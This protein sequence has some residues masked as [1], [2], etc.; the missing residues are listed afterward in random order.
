[1]FQ[2]EISKQP[3]AAIGSATAQVAAL[4]FIDNDTAQKRRP[5]RHSAAPPQSRARRCAA[6]YY[7]GYARAPLVRV[8]YWAPA[9]FDSLTAFGRTAPFPLWLLCDRKLSS[10]QQ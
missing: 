8:R 1:M 10:S 4:S 7:G 9:L 2:G 5:R 6:A 3:V